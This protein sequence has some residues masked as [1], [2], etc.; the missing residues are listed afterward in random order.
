[1]VAPVE[2]K[3]TKK[4]SSRSVEP[5]SGYS[6][7]SIQ[8]IYFSNA[9]Q[10]GCMHTKRLTL[11]LTLKIAEFPDGVWQEGSPRRDEENKKKFIQ[12]GRPVRELFS[13]VLQGLH[14][15]QGLLHSR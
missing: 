10:H 15:R 13:L 2:L 9:N 11:I 14:S 7:M 6:T 3:K 12:I 4:I 5:F 1:M 8:F